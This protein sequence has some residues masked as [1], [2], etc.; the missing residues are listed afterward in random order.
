MYFVAEELRQIMSKLGF[1]TVNEMV[2][3]SQ[4]INMSV[5]INHFKAKGIDLTKIL[6]KPKVSKKTKLYNIEKQDHGLKKSLDF[7]IL[8]SA[9]PAIHNKIKQV[10]NYPIRSTNRTCGTI[11]SNDIKIH[12][13]EGLPK[14]T[15]TVNFSGTAGQTLVLYGKG[16]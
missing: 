8:K 11:I 14:D 12:G 16:G 15:L 5:A 13:S 9:K 2:G 4:K 7:K 10:L 6:Y 3:Q 1:R